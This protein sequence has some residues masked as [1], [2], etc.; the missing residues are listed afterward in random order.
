[1]KEKYVKEKAKVIFLSQQF[2]TP[3]NPTLTH[4]YSLCGLYN[5]KKLCDHIV[6]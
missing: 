4:V 2:Q 5:I 6:L 3:I 1:M